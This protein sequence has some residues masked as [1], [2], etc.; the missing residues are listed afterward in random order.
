M[1]SLLKRWEII[2]LIAGVSAALIILLLNSGLTLGIDF[3]GGTLYQIELQNQVSSDEISRIANIISQRIDP[4]GLKDVRVSPV[5]GKYILVQLSE[6]NPVELEKIEAR[7]RQQG[8]FEATL[9]GETIFTGDEIKS[10]LRGTS[11]YGV[12][13]A[14]TGAVTWRMPFVLSESA[15]SRFT[16]KAFHQCDVVSIGTDGSPVY[17]CAK[18]FFFLDK[19]N[20]LIVITEE[21]YETDSETLD[22]GNSFADIP[23]GTGIDSLIENSQLPFILLEDSNPPS[24]PLDENII[25]SALLKTKDAIVSPGVSNETILALEAKG[26]TVAREAAEKDIPWIWSAT[27]ARQVIS[28]TEEVTN[29]DVSDPS[30]AEVFTTLIIRGTRSSAEVARTDLEEL[31]ILLESGSLPTPVK[32]ISRETISPSLGESFLTYVIIMGLL[33]IMTVA[34]VILVRYKMPKLAIP[35][36]IIGFSETV[37]TLGFLS[38]FRIPLDLA[39]FAGIIAAVGTGVDSEIVITDEILRGEKSEIHESLLAR[40]KNALYIIVASAATITAALFPI[41]IFS[42]GLG[43][44]VGFA[45]TTIVGVLIGIF[46]TRPGFSK[47]IQHIINK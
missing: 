5:G 10:V 19:P 31:T 6:T 11:N 38:F 33:A 8:R 17:D 1:N 16:E 9:N 42:F 44:L 40:A 25:A 4:T 43:K 34:T 35:I 26:F 3:K 41:F 18:T 36:I 46:I 12:F 32:S 30:K 13:G 24:P 47:I 27:N 2:L 39:A 29:E 22:A 28:L 23:P 20:A 21:E 7:I 37:M 45:I 14:G 15:A